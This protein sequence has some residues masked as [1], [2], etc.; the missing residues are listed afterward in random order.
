MEEKNLKVI[1]LQVENI[2]KINAINMQFKD[3]GITEIVGY[4]EQGKSTCLD[5][6]AW[7]L[8]GDNY[9][10]ADWIRHGTDRAIAT[11][12][13]S[14]YIITKT[15]KG[16]EQK[17]TLE[18]TTKDGYPKKTPQTFLNTLF[19]ELTF[20]PLPFVNLSSTEKLKFMMNLVK[21]DFTTEDRELSKYEEERK[22]L[23]RQIKDCG[24][25][26]PMNPVQGV[27]IS[28]I[29]EKRV[30]IERQNEIIRKNNASKRTKMMQE[31]NE[32]NYIQKEKITQKANKQQEILTNENYIKNIDKQIE[33]LLRNKTEK[34][35]R[36]NTLQM[37][38]SIIGEPETLKTYDESEIKQ[39]PLCETNL[40]D[41][42]IRT[43]S[44]LNKKAEEYKLYLL[45]KTE[46]E[47]KEMKYKE[48]EEIIQCIRQSKQDKLRK[49]EL[50]ME[51][52]EIRE[53]AIYYK[54]NHCDNWSRSES[55]MVSLGLYKAMKPPLKAIFIDNGEQFD[56]NRKQ[57]IEQ[58]A[59][60]NDLQVILTVVGE[61]SEVPEGSFY[62][63]EGNVTLI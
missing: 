37:E 27:D 3:S 63:E 58:F 33:D 6:L 14:G 25:L 52:L 53:D 22:I 38:L 43:A 29:I 9:K 4:N 20:N 39:E 26:A 23:N 31:V 17:T 1:G 13:I 61:K 62:I 36:Q 18:I 47:N 35:Q 30:E 19:N 10:K 57:Q 7:L 50:P 28:G 49:A 32:F 56:P 55:Y 11:L 60:E 40:Y 2:G 48:T 12:E 46:K 21:I 5:V 42:E 54:G 8:G 45:K 59:N 51:G 16:P 24:Y 15:M 41:E 44:N 34:Q